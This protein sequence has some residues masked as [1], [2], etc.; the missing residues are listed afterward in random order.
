M[1]EWV[2]LQAQDGHELQG[3][4]ARPK[5]EPKAMLVVAMEIYGVNAHIRSVT[6]RWA[7]K[8]F[9]AIAPQYFDRYE[10]GLDLGYDDAGKA[11]ATELAKGV[12]FDFAVADTAAA[13]DWLENEYEK[14]VGIVGYC[15]GGS[16]AWLAA[17]R[18]PHISA[19]VGY[20]GRAATQFVN[21]KP[22]CPVMLHFGDQDASIPRSETQKIETVHPE[23]PLFHYEAGHAFN[24]DSDP[25]VYNAVAAR[26]ALKRTVMFFEQ[27]LVF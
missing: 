16:V 9:L 1:T 22:Q 20:Y 26:E 13:V 2:T 27:H 17:C 21:E 14:Q 5:G 3:Y 19:A 15:F 23:V 8:G 18:V 6:E 12:N 24:R 11:K 10:R 7:E 4:V 25:K